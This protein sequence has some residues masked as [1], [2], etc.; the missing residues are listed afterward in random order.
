MTDTSNPDRLREKI[1]RVLGQTPS[2]I[3]VITAA[4]SAG[5]ETGMLASWVQQA[6]F[7][8]PMITVCLRKDRFL[9]A[10]FEEVP[11][12]AVNIIGESQ[13]PLLKH[14]AAGFSPEGD[15]FIGVEIK[16]GIT[17]LPVLGDALGYLEGNITGRI[18][19]GDHML[20]TVAVVGAGTGTALNTQRPMV[21]IRKNGFTY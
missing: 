14:F 7:E 9:N 12:L 4:N 1:G 18:S 10:W 17:G 2:G 13:R 15:A 3:F 16:R 6:S 19:I 21:H 11:Q 20:Y 5:R 8:P